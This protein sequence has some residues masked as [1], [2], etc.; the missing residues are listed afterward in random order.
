VSLSNDASLPE[1]I[2]DE[3]WVVASHV[4][5]AIAA[6]AC[7]IT[8]SLPPSLY[9]AFYTWCGFTLPLLAVAGAW[10]VWQ[11]RRLPG[12]RRGWGFVSVGIAGYYLYEVLWGIG[13]LTGNPAART[14]ADLANLLFAPFVLIGVIRATQQLDS[15]IQ[16]R[17][18]FLDA[19]I[20]SLGAASLIYALF[21]LLG[22]VMIDGG[23]QHSMLRLQPLMDVL[24]L[25]GIALLWTRRKSSGMPAWATFIAAA[26]ICG[27]IGDA[28]FVLPMSKRI[29][30][31]W[32]IV[33]AW[34]ACWSALTVGVMRAL[35]PDPPIVSSGQL[36]RLPYVLAAACFAAL[37]VAVYLDDR[38]AIVSATIGSGLVTTLVLM[39]QYVT[40][41]E[42]TLMQVDRA[43][44]E[45]DSRLAALVRHGSDMLSIVNTQ[46]IIQ[47]ASPSHSWILGVPPEQIVGTDVRANIHRDD[48]A[49]ADRALANLYRGDAQNTS[50]VLRMRD[51]EGRWRWL[52]VIGSN[53]MDE[54]SINGVVL[55]SRDVSE[56]KQ[57]EE[58]LADQALRDPLTGL[59]NRRL[60]S[61]RVAH[62]IERQLRSESSVAVL[63]LDLDHFKFVNDTL[64]H[65]KGDALL[66]HVAERL[67]QAVRAGDTVARL[68]GDEFAVLLEDLVHPDEADATALRILDALERP[69][70]LDDREVF[71]HSS[72]GIAL[73]GD[74]QGV[75][76]LVTDADVAMY[77]AKNA[78]RNRMARFSTA[79]RTDIAERHDV[80]AALHR[81]LERDEFDLLY[82][83]IVNLR[84]GSVVGAEA[85]IRWRHRELGV[86]PPSRFIAIAEES[87][88]IVQI[89]RS[90]LRVAAR[91]A[92]RFRGATDRASAM[93]VGVNLSARQLL[94]PTLVS[95]VQAAM[96]DADAPGSALSVE[97]TETILASHEDAIIQRLQS[98]RDLGV[99]IALDDFGTG[100]S[101]LAYLRHYPIDV[102][103]VDRS[104]VSWDAAEIASDGVARA[105]ISIGQ[106]LSMHTVAEG[107]ETREQLEQLRELGCALG[108]GYL[109]SAPV[110][111]DEFTRFLQSWDRTTL[112]CRPARVAAPEHVV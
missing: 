39:R 83:P 36:S 2:E 91:D 47:Y 85:L 104:F 28:W 96:A 33:V 97:L 30:D 95:D 26:L 4:F 27:L 102:L 14:Y 63:L 54:P 41:G 65:A 82:Q 103:K 55:T 34:Y 21:K 13:W 35:R 71:V 3:R 112:S 24:T 37:A 29:V 72:I 98:L 80:E 23:E 84:N 64:G 108:Q 7:V 66:I 76:D 10:R 109:F 70:T 107:I 17:R 5:V 111:A 92:M 99:L 42:V 110:N 81:A 62:A 40:L 19:G 48:R 51:A 32:F 1:R 22:G 8:L 78:G 79:M 106:S 25:S 86:L 9:W 105:I 31:P 59:G 101:S 77:A 20:V 100:Y 73:A 75:D 38:A 50:L 49:H 68:G 56:R 88:L 61:D 87:D 15:P 57:L 89:G 44:A 46:S 60:F 52:E 53:L 18:N 45:A 90:M 43:R 16:R 69:F 93:R 67:R 11:R 58:M 94:S 12:A 6:A 74:D